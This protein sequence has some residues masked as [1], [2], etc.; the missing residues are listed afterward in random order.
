MASGRKE[1]NVSTELE[2]IQHKNILMTDNEIHLKFQRLW[3]DIIQGETFP[4]KRPLL[5][6][7]TSISTLESIMRN[8]EVWFSN[9]LYMNDIEE[10]KF[11]MIEGARAFRDSAEIRNACQTPEGYKLL[12]NTFDAMFHRYDTEHVFDT[13]IF[14]LSEHKP[15]NKD[16]LL[17]MWRGYGGNGHGAAIVFDSQ[18]IESIEGTVPL[19]ISKVSYAP[20]EKRRTWIEGKMM[21]FAALLRKHPIPPEKLYI[22]IHQL[23]ERIKI[24]A[25][26]SKHDGF[27]EEAEWRI[28]FLKE[29][30]INYKFDSMF[31][32]AVGRNGIEP[33]LKL[34]VE[35][36][37][38]NTSLDLSLEKIVYQIILGPM[39]ASPLAVNS[40]QRMLKAVG[41]PA[42]A[43]RVIASTTP[44][45]PQ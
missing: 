36:I 35:P 32:Y 15:E 29:R 3:N 22:P 44:Y 13:Y 34:K 28:A 27:S 39:L 8:D 26:F 45:R 41:K 9:P 24:F 2:P 21:E 18:K 40:V 31:S 19:I 30:D 17:S 11:G 5:A 1:S 7:Y 20:N 14:S 16:G 10:L 43:D 6:H 25:L 42:V 37:Q 12:R 4:Q 33:K 23:F 38:E